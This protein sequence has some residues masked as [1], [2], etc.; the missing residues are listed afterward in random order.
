M[1][2]RYSR[3]QMA[4]LWTEEHRF[5]TM[6]QV[7]IAACEAMSLQGKVPLAD[8]KQIKKKAKINVKEILEI[9]KI[10]KHDVIAFLTQVERSVGPAARHLHLGMTSSD[11]LDTALALQLKEAAVLLQED[12]FVLMEAVARLA[13]Q[14]KNSLMAGRTHGVHAEPISFGIKCAGWYSELKRDME[15]LL[16]AQKIISFGKVSGVVGVYAHLDPSIESLVC[17]KLGLKP[18]P[19]ATQV[20]PRDRHAEY[21]AILALVGSSLERFALEIRHLQKT[22]VLELEEPFSEGQR[23]SSAMPHKRNP[24]LCENICGLARLLRSYAQ[25]SLENVA[26]W[27]ERDISHSSVE[28]VILPDATILLDFMIDRMHSVLK[29]LRVYPEKMRE[30]LQKTFYV[31]ASQR[32]MLKILKSGKKKISRD[33]AYKMVQFLAQRAWTQSEDFK[34]L[35]LKDGSILSYLDPSQIEDCFDPEYFLRHTQTIFKHAGL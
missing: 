20:I 34:Q 16:R 22:E 31:L 8:L 13:K 35:V 24:I 32:L 10:V 26:L 5:Q 7:E 33:Q 27:H 28:R 17:K 2:P 15:R 6:L 9:E 3:D 4:A 30:N 14:H 1:I 18:E 23:G 12:L 11:V 19:V 21:L 29:D 25:A